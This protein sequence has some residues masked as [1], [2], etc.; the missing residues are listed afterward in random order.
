[1]DTAPAERA[2]SWTIRRDDLR[3]EAVQAL[4]R[5]HLA[6]MHAITPRHSAHALDLNA[7]R[8][9]EITFWTLWQGE[10]LL[11]CGAL[12]ELDPSTGEVKSMRTA[13]AHRGRGVASRLLEHIEAE[14]RRRDYARLCLETGSFDAFAP[15]QALYVKHGFARRGPFGSYQEDPNTVFFEKWL[16]R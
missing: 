10:E 13:E 6:H 7:L 8:A 5:E 15:A 3:G 12:K 4:L 2:A 1:M 9:P 11:G 14:A 16:G